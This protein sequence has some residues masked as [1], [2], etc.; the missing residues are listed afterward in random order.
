MPRTLK[1]AVIQMDSA[2]APTGER[3]ARAEALV[4]EAASS[5]AALVALPEFFNTGYAYSEANYARAETLEGPTATALRNW[6]ST[7]GVHVAG[8]FMHRD[9][10]EVYNTALLVAPDG[11]TWR[12]DKLYPFGWERAYFRE[13][14]GITIAETELGKL[15]MMI[16]WDA[17]HPNLWRRYAG[18]VEAM[19]VLSNPPKL[20]SADAVLPDG[21]RV[22]VRDLGAL[23]ENIYTEEEYFPGV[24]MDAQAAWLR[25]PVIA[26]S[27]AGQFST[28]LPLP[29]ISWGTYFAARPDLWSE[30]K[31]A[32]AI[33]L[34]TGYDKQTKVVAADGEVVA[35]V[36]ADG[37]GFA[38]AEVALPDAPPVPQA[39]QPPMQTTPLS[40]ALIDG[41]ASNATVSLYRA[42]HRRQWGARMAPLDRR[43]RTLTAGV[44]AAGVA[45]WLAGRRRK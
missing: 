28:H 34:E 36:E 27:G 23:G 15:G 40:Y 1:V 8:S 39:P 32:A 13:G 5:G 18:Q 6:A 10:D 37:D 20:S 12:Y 33:R 19:L 41:F 42:G 14:E 21:R 29:L 45:G 44:V 35:R 16:C 26:T 3:L 9:G 30:L 31:D 17:S 43:T 38:L 2:P 11:R 7:H 4:A 25:V 22:N 24:D